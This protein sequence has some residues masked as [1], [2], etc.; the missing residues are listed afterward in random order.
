MPIEK[1]SILV[2]GVG[3]GSVGE[4]IIF[5]LRLSK[6]RYKI[7]TVDHNPFSLGLYSA[8]KSYLVPSAT[9]KSY[10]NKLL[11]ICKK[12][13]VKALI[14]GSDIELLLI[15]QNR[16]LFQNENILPLINSKDVI[17]ICRNKWKTYLFLKNS[18]FYVPKSYLWNED[19]HM[20]KIDYPVIVK[21]Y[22]E[23]G[24]SRFVFIAQNNEELSFFCRYIKKQGSEPMVQKYVGSGDSEYT[25]EVLTS[26]EGE[27]LGSVAI[28]RRFQDRLST[29]Y[30][31]KNYEQ[32]SQPLYV[33]T[34]ISQG[35]I[36]DFHDIR[37]VSEKIALKMNSKGPINIQCRESEN[38]VYVFEINPRFSGT[39]SLR[40][41][42]GFNAP[43]SLIKKYILGEDIKKLSYKKGIVSRGLNN[44]FINFEEYNKFIS[45]NKNNL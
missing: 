10:L 40:A 7:I 28:K 20:N 37:K 3:G 24:G 23:T 34:G 25:V 18:G 1:I 8:D 22:L 32:N 17:N 30:S 21:P 41:L 16:D 2:T 43:D 31:L 6:Y 12:E 9:E 39:E 29:L 33:S 14:P 45:I 11:E 5:A 26:F 44:S 38:R 35:I 27:L 15:S 19:S 36:D 13:S 4:Q 42:A